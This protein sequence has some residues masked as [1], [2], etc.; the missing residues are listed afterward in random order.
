MQEIQAPISVL[1]SQRQIGML[2]RRCSLQSLWVEG[3]NYIIAVIQAGWRPVQ[4]LLSLF[5]AI[6]FQLA[7]SAEMLW[8]KFSSFSGKEWMCAVKTGLK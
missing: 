7:L 6:C 2:M 1:G 8:R 5:H 4:S 3:T